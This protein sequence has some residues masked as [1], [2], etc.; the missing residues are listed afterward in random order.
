[1][2]KTERELGEADYSPSTGRDAPAD[3]TRGVGV[4]G[5]LVIAAGFV[6]VGFSYLFP[7]WISYGHG[8]PSY[9]VS[10]LRHDPHVTGYAAAYFTWIG[11]VMVVATAAFAVGGAVPMLMREASARVA[12]FLGVLSAAMSLAVISD[13]AAPRTLASFWKYVSSG[14]Y[15]AMGGFLLVA[16]GGFLAL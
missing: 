2:N 10:G 8:G 11:W 1:V 15:F 6:M 9:T 13:L 7:S 4:V 16:I 3:G 5:L 12:A 14:P